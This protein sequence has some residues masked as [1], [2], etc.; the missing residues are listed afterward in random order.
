MTTINIK[1]MSCNHCVI[2][3]T[4]ALNQIDGIKNVKVD[5]GKGKASF[6]EIKPVDIEI[7]KERIRKAGY[8]VVTRK[9]ET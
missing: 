2:A 6:D 8:Q 4:K 9:L 5:L 1:G 3:V 7:I